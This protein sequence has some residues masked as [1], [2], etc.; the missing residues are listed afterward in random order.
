MSCNTLNDALS[1]ELILHAT[2]IQTVKQL[3]LN[4]AD[5]NYQSDEGWCLLFELVSLNLSQEIASLKNMP[6]NLEIM[7]NKGRN[8]LFWSIYHEHHEVLNTL[9]ELGC[10][11]KSPVINDLPALH[12]AVYKNNA[13]IV[14]LLLE[15]GFNIETKDPYDNTAMDY[16]LH[17]GHRSMIDLLHQRGAHTPNLDY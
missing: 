11:L 14:D 5:I 10:D 8:A 9:I 13:E 3:L 6:F 15:K 16:A 4:G 2:D 12:Y 7:D 1:S 17:Y